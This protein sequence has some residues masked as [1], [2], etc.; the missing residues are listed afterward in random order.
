MV[1]EGGGI[2]SPNYTELTPRLL[3]RARRAGL[4]VVPWTVNR[5]ADQVRL[6][7]WGVDG[8]ITDDP[9][10]ARQALGLLKPPPAGP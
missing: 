9:V 6:A 1:A 2:W 10:G 3:E 8:I 7:A 5:L 4:R